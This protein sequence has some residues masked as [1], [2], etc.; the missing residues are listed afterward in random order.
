MCVCVCGAGVRVKSKFVCSTI[1]KNLFL[2]LSSKL[3]H[4]VQYYDITQFTYTHNQYTLVSLTQPAACP[5]TDT[6]RQ[7]KFVYS[8]SNTINQ[9]C[10]IIQ[11][12][13]TQRACSS[14]RLLSL[15]SSSLYLQWVWR[16]KKNKMK[17]DRCLIIG[18]ITIQSKIY[19]IWSHS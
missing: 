15:V 16:K 7:H 17:K 6:R 14:T 12:I 11:N 19:W 8:H 18:S 1:H 3:S 9:K 4:L 2:S 10:G 13:D 5:A